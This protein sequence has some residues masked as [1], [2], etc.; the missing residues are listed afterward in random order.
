MLCWYKAFDLLFAVAI[1]K[2]ACSYLNLLPHLNYVCPLK[3]LTTC[4]FVE[5]S[6]TIKIRLD[7]DCPGFKGFLSGHHIEI[8]LEFPVAQ[9]IGVHQLSVNSC[10]NTLVPFLDLLWV[11]IHATA[12][13]ISMDYALAYGRILAYN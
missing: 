3:C 5:Y 4:V 6:R 8:H 12:G 10:L 11:A 2:L 9:S 7:D 13:S 1:A